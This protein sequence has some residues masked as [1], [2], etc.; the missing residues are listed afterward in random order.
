M[1]ALAGIVSTG[2]FYYRNYEQKYRAEMEQQLSAIAELKVGELVQWR[3]ERLGDASILANLCDAN[4]AHTRPG[5][6]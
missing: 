5:G 3:K 2:Y 4:R 6:T 1:F